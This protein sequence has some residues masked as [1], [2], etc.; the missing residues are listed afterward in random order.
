MAFRSL[1]PKSWRTLGNRRRVAARPD[2]PA[3]ETKM[4]S[5]RRHAS[6]RSRLVLRSRKRGQPRFRPARTASTISTAARNVASISK[7]VLS[8]KYASGARLSGA[9]AR[10]L[11]RSSRRRMSASTSAASAVAPAACSSAIRRAARTC[12]VAATKIFTSAS[13]KITVPMSRP[14]ITAPGGVRPKRRCKSTSAARTSA[15]AETNDAASPMAW[16]LSVGSSKRAGS[17]AGRHR[18]TPWPPRDRSSRC[19]DGAGRN[20]GRGVWR[21]CLCR[22]RPGR[23]WQ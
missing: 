10:V 20:A 11:S 1:R 9:A 17:S 21:A 22:R 7:C 19:R 12:G 3:I 14:S 18:A 6:G 13:G 23:R 5:V 15:I 4:T 2:S 8:S 16:L